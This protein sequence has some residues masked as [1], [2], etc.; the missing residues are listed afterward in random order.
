MPVERSEC[1]VSIRRGVGERLI[2][3]REAQDYRASGGPPDKTT[4]PDH[5]VPDWKIC[6]FGVG[7]PV[8]KSTKVFHLARADRVREFYTLGPLGDS[9]RSIAE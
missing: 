7:I 5:W 6:A 8:E 4:S 3:L 2:S 9:L 1:A